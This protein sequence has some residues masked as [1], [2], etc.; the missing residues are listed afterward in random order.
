MSMRNR[1]EV[2]VTSKADG[3]EIATVQVRDATA[4][5]S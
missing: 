5:K 3:R 1:I 2:G 4:P